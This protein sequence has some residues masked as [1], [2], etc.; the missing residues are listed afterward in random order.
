M[1]HL[2]QD[3]LTVTQICHEVGFGNVSNFNR[4]FL[5]VKSMPP[6]KFRGLQRAGRHAVAA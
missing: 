3:D 2:G 6:S 4:Q 1:L 5:A